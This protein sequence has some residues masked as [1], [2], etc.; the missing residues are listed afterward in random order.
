MASDS[1]QVERFRDMINQAEAE[2]AQLPGYLVVS[3]KD[4]NDIEAVMVSRGLTVSYSVEQ[5]SHGREYHITSHTE[6]IESLLWAI[7]V[8][9]HGEGNEKTLHTHHYEAL[10]TL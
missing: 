10:S 6:E 2:T 3:P 7:G 1:K 5:G 9:G 8:V 4:W